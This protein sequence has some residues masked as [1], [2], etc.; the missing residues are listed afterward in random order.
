M[1]GKYFLF[2]GV[3]LFFF[4]CKGDPEIL[5]KF[6]PFVE[7][8][9]AS[10]LNL[11]GVTLNAKFIEGIDKPIEF[12]FIFSMQELFGQDNVGNMVIAEPNGLQFSARLEPPALKGYETYYF[13]PFIK[14]E[15]GF[16]VY[17]PVSS[18]EF[19]GP[20]HLL[21]DIDGNIYPIVQIG[22]QV[23]IT[24]N[25]R[26][27]RYRNGDPIITNLTAAQWQSASAGAYSI[28]PH[29]S[30]N[31]Y[32][33]EEQVF[34][35]FGALYNWYAVADERGLCPAG[36]RVPTDRDW[37]DLEGFADTEYGIG[38]NM[39]NS[40]SET[41][42]KDA[43]MKLKINNL[44]EHKNFSGTDDFG[45]SARPGGNRSSTNGSF[46]GVQYYG[47]YWTATVTGLNSAMIR[48]FFPNSSSSN[49]PGYKIGR[50]S[51]GNKSG[52][53]VRCLKDVE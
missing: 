39:W 49:Q 28:Y 44:L 19:Q 52:L 3:L 6:Y 23:W 9:E 53:S 29:T 20:G 43:G 16:T 17:G 40:I 22:E 51:W 8:P 26:V 50:A 45:F 4:S 15:N 42:G 30:I 31:G 32:S 48:T 13:R 35:V 7:V 14:T 21:E 18:F 47:R 36:W 2:I 5:P 33:S 25:L 41:R 46:G 37:R 11:E 34:N 38:H 24:E 12:G 27:T 10:D 1:K